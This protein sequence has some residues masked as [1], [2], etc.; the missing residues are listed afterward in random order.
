[1]TAGY[2]KDVL[3][4]AWNVDEATVE[5]LLVSQKGA[6]IVKL[7]KKERARPP[8]NPAPNTWFGDFSF[9]LEHTQPEVTSEGGTFNY[10]TKFKMPLLKKVGL[11]AAHAELKPVRVR[12]EAGQE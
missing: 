12:C 3:A 6:A 2:S 11:S 8:S 7:E 10:V 9:N 4:A 1:M 5:K